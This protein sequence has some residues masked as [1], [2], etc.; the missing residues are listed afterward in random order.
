MSYINIYI[1]DSQKPIKKYIRNEVYPFV[2][3]NE[4][5]KN[6]DGISMYNND[7][8]LTDDYIVTLYT[9]TFLINLDRVTSIFNILTE[10]EDILLHT[11]HTYINL[12][13]VDFYKG[14]VT[15][16]QNVEDNLINKLIPLPLNTGDND[17]SL[18]LNPSDNVKPYYD[19]TLANC[20]EVL[21]NCHE[22]RDNKCKSTLEQIQKKT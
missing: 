8:E 14:T 19:G 9:K 13:T 21:K 7:D 10:S 6:I 4:H 3:F 15:L 11:D 12:H 17:E 2:L 20:S 5:V 18:S 22:Q 16:R 1:K